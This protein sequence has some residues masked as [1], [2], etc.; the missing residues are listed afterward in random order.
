MG[1]LHRFQGR[2]PGQLDEP[3]WEALA[4]AHQHLV[5]GLAQ[6]PALA[7]QPLP[8]QEEEEALEEQA[9]PTHPQEQELELELAVVRMH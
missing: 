8:L 3:A 7:R 6:L 5:Q 4:A 9:A 2:L 1:G